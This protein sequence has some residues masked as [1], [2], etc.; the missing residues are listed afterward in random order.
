MTRAMLND[1]STSKYFWVEAVN[2][3]YYLQNKILI[4]PILKDTPYEL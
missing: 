2:T 3:A 4:R 1:N